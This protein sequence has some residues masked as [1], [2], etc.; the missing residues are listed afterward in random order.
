MRAEIIS[1]GKELLLGEIVD[2]NARQLGELLAKHGIDHARRATVDDNTA[3]ISA[4]ITEALGRS[5][6]VFTIGG[7]GPTYDDVTREGIASAIGDTLIEDTDIADALREKHARRG[8]A[9]NEV[10]ARM[11][12]RPTSAVPIPNEVGTAPGL[13]IEVGDKLVVAL[14]GPPSE[15]AAML[16]SSVAATLAARSTQ[17]SR[18]RTLRIVGI[19]ESVIERRLEDLMQSVNPSVAPYVKPMEVH[20]RILAH[21]SSANETNELI[22]PVELAIRERLGIAIFSADDESLE[23]VV[24]SLLK[25]KSQTVATAESCTGG[26]LGQRLTSVPGASDAYLGGYIT[27]SN[28]LKAREVSVARYD[29][30]KYGAVSEE[31]ARQMAEGAIR[32]TGAD[33]AIGI[34]GIAGPDGGTESKPVGLVYISLAGPRGVEVSK[35]IFAGDREL[36]RFRAT[37][38]ALDMLRRELLLNESDAR[39]AE[40]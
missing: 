33:F 25:R 28:E 5:E 15:F 23:S 24:I 18:S 10:L 21:A 40:S 26:M 11:A 13:R 6:I 14:P 36:I 12:L 2:S 7:L 4:A 9:W 17:S 31:V 22:A 30:A 34:T 20:V 38:V 16:E 19:P 37:Q 1:I 32:H 27:Y 35:Q 8:R 29:L 39:P 3:D